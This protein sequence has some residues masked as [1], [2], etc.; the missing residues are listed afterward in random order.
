ML[1][2]SPLIA[3]VFIVG[4]LPGQGAGTIGSM[5]IE[6]SIEFQGAVAGSA[7]ALI[8]HGVK[9]SPAPTLFYAVTLSPGFL[10]L[11]ASGG[12]ILGV[13]PIAVFTGSALV[14][15]S[16]VPAA[17]RLAIPFV[18]ATSAT[19]MTLYAQAGNIDPA[20]SSGVAW[21]DATMVTFGAVEERS[22]VLEGNT[23]TNLSLRYR[24]ADG[25][26]A[27]SWPGFAGI[28]LLDL[29][30][31]ATHETLELRS[32]L[33][34]R[35]EFEGRARIRFP[36]GARLYYY[37]DAAQNYGFF[38]VLGQG[39]RLVPLVVS[40]QAQGLSPF[41]PLVSASPFAPIVA[42]PLAEGIP[43]Y[44]GALL[45]LVRTDGTNWPGLAS[46]VKPVAFTGALAGYEPKE[47][48]FTFAA[49]ALFSTD[50][51]IFVRMN[52]DGT[53]A[54]IIPLPPSGGQVPSEVDDQL[55]WSADGSRIA[56]TAGQ[57][58][59]DRDVYVVTAAGVAT[60]LTQSA[61]E[62]Q[63]V[64]YG[65]LADGGRL[66]LAPDGSRIA[67]VFTSGG[68]K[69]LFLKDTVVGAPVLQLTTNATFEDTIDQELGIQFLARSVVTFNAGAGA[70]DHDHYKVVVNPQSTGFAIQNVTGTSGVM[71][72]PFLAGATLVGTHLARLDDGSLL[73][74]LSQGAGPQR[75]VH[76]STQGVSTVLATGLLAANPKT[77]S[78]GGVGYVVATTTGASVLWRIPAGG[79]PVSL[80]AAP[81]G[82]Q[83]RSLASD[84]RQERL[85]LTVGGLGQP[86][87]TYVL[88]GSA[89]TPSLV[90]GIPPAILAPS[91]AHLFSG[92]R[93]IATRPAFGLSQLF[94]VALDGT[95]TPIGSSPTVT[96]ML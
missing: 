66:A 1:R 49:G 25:T 92:Q 14:G 6:P 88:A 55:A 46:P 85:I 65:D 18:P 40:A 2:F 86:D 82:V 15:P 90:A 89:T 22:L 10:P 52:E 72:P 60:N 16:P 23:T 70:N 21:T 38:M 5:G 37:R 35:E 9:S 7:S 13:D 47:E 81:A 68:S 83:I 57:D 17:N 78:L 43:E 39:R 58:D 30:L 11:P 62:Y 44:P 95:A 67:Y 87:S 27:P 53:N 41:E 26:S 94:R 51:S 8:F 71:T 54:A 91:V 64:S 73:M 45:L 42:I 3:L 20:A 79:A 50:R 80:W 48:S 33:P 28:E 34:V 69:E 96:L 24:L 77:A 31:A 63:D 61:G 29:Q 12:A 93:L 76:A 32:D 4:L 59:N 74:V 36:T 84:P 75:L 56:F 19:G